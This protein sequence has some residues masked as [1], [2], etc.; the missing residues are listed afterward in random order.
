M[1]V[2][3]KFMLNKGFIFS[4]FAVALCSNLL[5]APSGPFIGGIIGATSMRGEHTYTT[6]D[7]PAANKF[8][9]ISPHGGINAG[10]LISMKD[11]KVCVGGEIYFIVGGPSSKKELRTADNNKEGLYSISNKGAAG[12]SLITGMMLNPRIMAYAR[13]GYEVQNYEFK[14]NE[15]TFEAPNNKTY[16]KR[17]SGL[18]P[19]GGILFRITPQLAAMVDATVPVVNKVTIRK[20]DTNNRSMEY[21]PSMQRVSCRLIYTF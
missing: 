21:S 12:L 4:F 9:K 2:W 5:A 8:K 10:Y 17:V 16:K 7:K 11:G 20:K 18:A 19:G 15:L 14:Y 13:V 6:N 1:F 3:L